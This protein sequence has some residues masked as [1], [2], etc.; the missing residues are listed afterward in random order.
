VS[1]DLP[2]AR[3][4]LDGS[5]PTSWRNVEDLKQADVATS[6]AEHLDRALL[7]GFAWTAA[8]RWTS[9]VLS[10][11][12][13]LVVANILNPVDYG[14]VGMSMLVLTVVS[15]IN[16]F[17]VTTAIVTLRELPEEDL[18]RL[19]AFA[20]SF[21][22]LCFAVGALL[23]VPIGAYFRVSV[24]PVVI[25][26][27]SVGFILSSLQS[28]PSAVLQRDLSFKRLASVDLARSLVASVSA[29]GFALLGARYWSLVG[30]EL[31]A[32]ATQTGILIT[33]RPTGYLWS[34][35][36]RVRHAIA[37]GSRTVVERLSW[38]MYSNADFAVAGRMLGASALGAYSFAWTLVS[39]PVEKVTS[40]LGRV[41]PT[42]LAASSDDAQVM[43]RYVL[44]ITE[45][46][47]LLTFPATAGIALTAPDFIPLAFGQ[48]WQMAILPLQLLS[49][50]AALRSIMPVIV[51]A[52]TARRDIRF[53]MWNGVA[54]AIVF[55]ICFYA[56]GR[57][58]GIQG[59]AF[60][61]LVIYPLSTV[62]LF[63]RAISTNI[64]SLPGYLTSLAP[65]VVCTLIMCMIVLAVRWVMPLALRS[66]SLSLRFGAE[67]I[68]GVL[69]YL[70][71]LRLRYPARAR[72]ALAILRR[73][74]P[75]Q[76][77]AT[78]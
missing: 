60:A 62:P 66:P 50:C 51:N 8:A 11:A 6:K 59:I 30:A 14:I 70:V 76:I 61:W 9:Q 68:L 41:T 36:T 48:K 56:G 58:A 4:P 24:L 27:Q 17:G 5:P 77:F 32:A 78:G 52:M 46:L 54:S 43:R 37:F 64:F 25:L 7:R 33:L 75:A 1:E 47:A 67:V 26:V 55:P 34:G 39:L 28:V 31:L 42:V 29:L 15:L 63:W 49:V 71:A 20:L 74:S 57:I 19:N 2:T 53:L 69:S 23:A 44:G 72:A 65:A 73:R 21:G 13:T 18:R 38:Y 3:P 10:W 35:F 22:F 12:S 40:L 45:G 16:E